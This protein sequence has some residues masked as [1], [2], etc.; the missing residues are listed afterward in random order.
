MTTPF[1]SILL[2]LSGSRRTPVTFQGRK[3][4]LLQYVRNLENQTRIY[5]ALLWVPD[6][7]AWRGQMA[8][9]Q[10]SVIAKSRMQAGTPG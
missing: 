7:A 6:P 4:P 5:Y 2:C 10:A 8:R 3:C 1:T 9:R